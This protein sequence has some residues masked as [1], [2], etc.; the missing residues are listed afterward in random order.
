MDVPKV[1]ET[2][3]ANRKAGVGQVG[4][5]SSDHDGVL[6]PGPGGADGGAGVGSSYRT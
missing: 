5:G 4:V 6:H 2:S 3:V 1:A